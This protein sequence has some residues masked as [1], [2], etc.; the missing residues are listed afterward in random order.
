MG[1]APGAP[2]EAVQVAFGNVHSTYVAYAAVDDDHFA[3]VAVVVFF[4]QKGQVGSPKGLD[5]HSVLGKMAVIPLVAEVDD[6]VVHHPHFH[7]LG[8][9]LG[10]GVADALG[11]IVGFE[12]EELDVYEVLR[13]VDVSKEV[14][15]HG[16]ERGVGDGA[17][18]LLVVGR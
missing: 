13:G 15:D 3:V 14:V 11:N 2:I 8:C 17:V 7:A 10:Q 6:V 12:F 18:A 4:A 5:V 16:G 9:F 1:V